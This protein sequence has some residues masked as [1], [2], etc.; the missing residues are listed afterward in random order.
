MRLLAVPRDRRQLLDRFNQH[1]KHCKA[2][3]TAHQQASAAHRLAGVLALI[4]GSA[5][6]V[7]VTLAAAG[8]VLMPPG[9][10]A[11]AAAGGL[12]AA[13]VA[14]GSSWGLAGGLAVLAAVLGGAYVAL[15]KLVEK[16]VFV[17]YDIAHVGKRPAH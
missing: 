16:F 2:C 1:T 4:A 12:S 6:L 13:Q 11:V 17:D 3:R 8:A 9:A 5:A 10:A 14:A 7:M 15:G